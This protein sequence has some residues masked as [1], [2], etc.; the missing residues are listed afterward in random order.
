MAQEQFSVRER[1]SV[2]TGQPKKYRVI[3]HNDD[4]TTMDFVIEVL[5]TVFHK[6]EAE[7]YAIMMEVHT[8]DKGTAGIY[9]YDI[10]MTKRERAVEMAREERFP[11]QITV[12]PA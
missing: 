3:L 1:E 4:F 11:L 12:E 10:A 6:S 9:S 2:R 8:K 5:M 7:A